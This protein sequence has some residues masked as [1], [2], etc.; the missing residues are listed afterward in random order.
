MTASGRRIGLFGG[1]FDPIHLGH[2]QMAEAVRQALDLDEMLM[3]VA[4]DPWQKRGRVITPAEDRYAMVEAACREWTGLLASRMELDRGG[5][6]YT[7]DTVRQLR[8]A[9]PEARIYLVVGAD[10]VADLPTWHQ[11]A[12]LRA[13]VELAVVDR[14]GTPTAEVP[15]GWRSVRVEVDPIDLSSTELR[16]R[17]DAG[18]SLTGVLPDGVIRCISERSL[19]ATER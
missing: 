14:P 11:E 18:E 1:T 9:E 4:N 2:I 8:A 5:A 19:Y 13:L 15:D 10:V 12:E 17:L 6:T 3:M 7:V 16:R